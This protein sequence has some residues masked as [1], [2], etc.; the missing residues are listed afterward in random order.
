MEK[1][2]GNI[3]SSFFSPLSHFISGL[4]WERVAAAVLFRWTGSRIWRTRIGSLL[5]S[6][7]ESFQLESELRPGGRS[8]S[9]RSDPSCTFRVVFFS[10]S[11]SLVFFFF[12]AHLNIDKSYVF[13]SSPPTMMC[14]NTA[15]TQPDCGC[16]STSRNG[17]PSRRHSSKMKWERH[18]ES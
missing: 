9:S 4:F 18:E 8:P 12:F 2:S 11:H 5:G 10:R 3:F 13:F 6:A 14:V 7:P 1:S 16:M 17:D 15:R